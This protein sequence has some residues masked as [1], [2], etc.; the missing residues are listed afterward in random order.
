MLLCSLPS[1]L[2]SCF[3]SHPGAFWGAFLAPILAVMV[4][5]I[6]I[7][8]WVIVVLV[9]HTRGTAARKKE[10]VSN[11]TI[12]RLMI[13]ISGVMFLFGLTWLFAILTF[14]APGLRETFQALF[15]VF[16]SFQGFFI[17]LFFCVFSK[18]AREYWKEVLSCGR[19]TS[20]FLHP[21]QTRNVSSS[22]AGAKKF[23]KVTVSTGINSSSASEKSGYASETISKVGNHYE[24]NTVI[25]QDLAAAPASQ[26]EK[27][28]LDYECP[29]QSIATVEPTT[30]NLK[31][32]CS[33]SASKV[34]ESEA[35]KDAPTAK[36]IN[37]SES[38]GSV[39][40][41][42]V[43]CTVTVVI[44]ETAFSGDA[45]ANANDPQQKEAEVV[46][47]EGKQE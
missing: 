2:I 10:S 47:R 32:D 31:G 37:E 5:N 24:S 38:R 14:S 33:E 6:V 28:P 12:I 42:V 43:T 11:K 39:C 34:D 30:Q 35:S 44:A 15:T 9:R 25:K 1:S 41:E 18:E 7:F 4:F 26:V 45:N 8:I 40:E 27:I 22:G 3:L 23:K 16:N 13:S 19:Y 20:Q 29:K 36:D 21:S 46:E 17:F